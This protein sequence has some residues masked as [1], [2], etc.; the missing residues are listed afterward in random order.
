MYEVKVKKS[1][2]LNIMQKNREKH[3]AIFEKAI[4]G[5]RKEVIRHLD[6]ALKA[7]KSGKKI[8][9]TVKLIQPQDHTSDYDRIIGMLKMS[10]DDEITID[11][12]QYRQY[13]LDQWEWSRQ[14]SSTSA[15]YTSSSSL[16]LG[17]IYS[18]K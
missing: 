3:W 10:V 18:D 8:I 14:F 2:L 6:F 9:T 15:S 11:S 5:Y 12:E 17:S 4:A 16:S 1:E 13:I 7:A